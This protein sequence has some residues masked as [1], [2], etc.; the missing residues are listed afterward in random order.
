MSD[1]GMTVE[2]RVRGK[3]EPMAMISRHG[4]LAALAV[5]LIFNLLVTPNFLQAQT[6]AVNVSQVATIALVAVGMTLVIATGGIDLSVGAVMALSGAM[7]PIIFTSEFAQAYPVPG[8]AAAFLLP[9]VAAFCCGMFNGALVAL[10][11]VQPII[12]TLIFFISGRGVAQVLTN[13]NLQ[14]FTNPSFSYIG[15][16]RLL[17]IPVQGWL[18]ALIA[19][20]IWYVIRYTASGRYLLAVG[21]NERAARMAGV[22]VTRVKIMAYATCSVLSGL[23]GLIVV[24]INSASDAARIGNLMEL[25]AIA[26]AVVGGAVLSGGRAPIWGAILGAVVIQLVKYTL[27]ANGVADEIALIAKAGIIVAAVYAQQMRKG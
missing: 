11:G 19:A 8:L 14:T 24:A 18:V 26:A 5:L 23:S 16:A 27:L 9:L 2:N 25:D 10:L 12:A 3:R 22:P 4:G 13:G 6:L 1:E 21:G 15:T 17:G 20:V 7:A